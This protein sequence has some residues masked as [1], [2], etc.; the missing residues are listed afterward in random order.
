M[1]SITALIPYRYENP[2]TRLSTVLSLK[3]REKLS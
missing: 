2:K 1:K 3:E